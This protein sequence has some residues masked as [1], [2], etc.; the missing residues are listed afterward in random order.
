MKTKHAVSVEEKRKHPRKACLI[1]VECNIKDNIFTNYVQNISN[2]GVFIETKDSFE[3]GQR[4]TLKILA[5]YNLTNVK[6]LVGEIVRIDLTGIAVRFK[7]ETPEQKEMIRI[8][9]ENV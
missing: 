5:P 9:V 3:I 6:H 1:S 8:F 7:S 2:D 4:V